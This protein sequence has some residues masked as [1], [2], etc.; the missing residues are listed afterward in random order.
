M[1]NNAPFI[2]IPNK[3]IFLL[4]CGNLTVPQH[5]EVDHNSPGRAL[6]KKRKKKE[7]R[8]HYIITLHVRSKPT[9]IFAIVFIIVQ[10]KSCA[11]VSARS[12]LPP[13]ASPPHHL[14]FSSPFLLLKSGSR[15]AG[16]EPCSPDRWSQ[17]TFLRE[18]SESMAQNKQFMDL[19][20]Y[21]CK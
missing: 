5:S 2:V 9:Q 14:S 3:N 20:F 10:I 15:A 11:V 4:N 17:T 12:L 7:E 21:S 18:W 6:A 8:T 16:I 19:C 13:L 1:C